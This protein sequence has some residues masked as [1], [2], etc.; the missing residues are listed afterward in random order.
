MDRIVFFSRRHAAAQLPPAGAVLISI[1]Q[2]NEPQ[3]ELR[4]GWAAILYSRFHDDCGSTMGLEQFTADHAAQMLE[5]VAQHRS[6][7]ELYVHCQ[8][9]RSRSAAV[10]L[11]FSDLLGVPCFKPDEG[12]AGGLSK[13]R[14][15]VK[16]PDYK[17]HNR[18]VHAFL[19]DGLTG[20]AGAAFV[21]PRA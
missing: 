14:V 11:F 3:L 17:F 6:A 5:F 12:F 4:P 9:G 1:H 18:R 20:P 15:P 19:T 13:R 16:L 10:A 8:V 2:N 7:S 21:Q